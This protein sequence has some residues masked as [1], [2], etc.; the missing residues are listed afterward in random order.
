MTRSKDLTTKLEH[1]KDKLLKEKK[2]GSISWEEDR[3]LS[4][5]KM[6]LA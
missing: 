1:I 5:N 6:K 3:N 2:K 4:S